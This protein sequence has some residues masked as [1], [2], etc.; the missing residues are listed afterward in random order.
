MMV[1]LMDGL[2]HGGTSPVVGLALTAFFVVRVVAFFAI[3]QTLEISLENSPSVGLK[4]I[5]N[6]S[7]PIDGSSL[8]I[9]QVEFFAIRMLRMVVPCH[10]APLFF[11]RIDFRLR[12][13]ATAP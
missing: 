7:D 5:E 11:V 8:L 3:S 1:S 4:M 2:A 12:R 10:F 6:L 13:S 9:G